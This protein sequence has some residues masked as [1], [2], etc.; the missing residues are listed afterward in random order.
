M[1]L[2][3]A[4]RAPDM[5]RQDTSSPWR[6]IAMIGIVLGLAICALFASGFRDTPA[7]NS[8]SNANVDV[9][10]AEGPMLGIAVE[11]KQPLHGTMRL[12][13]DEPAASAGPGTAAPA[14]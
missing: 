5:R 10:M 7:R 8:G 3:R 1:A 2:N 4:S 12:P 6:T 11:A 9:K 13:V 14:K